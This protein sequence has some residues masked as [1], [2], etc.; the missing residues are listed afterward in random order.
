MQH[1]E[2]F[3][4]KTFED[5]DTVKAR[6][7]E[8]KDEWLEKKPGQGNITYMSHNTMRQILDNAVRGITY[9]QFTVLEQWREEIFAF[10]KHTNSYYFDGY[11]YHVK[12]SMVIPGIGR[13]EQYGSKPGIGGK[14]NQDSAYKAAAS[15]CFTK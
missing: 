3:F 12:G 8:C 10:N 15:N 6:L 13:R 14:S 2:M 5:I 9:W 1:M 7:R 4:P 11:V